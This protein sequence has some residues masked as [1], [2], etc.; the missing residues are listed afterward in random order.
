MKTPLR[1]PKPQKLITLETQ[2]QT[3]QETLL[4][5]RQ[6]SGHRSPQETDQEI[7]Q[8]IRHKIYKEFQKESGDANLLQISHNS[9]EKSAIR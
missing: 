7:S 8:Q 3:R 2:T 4:A 9:A 5:A 1:T 6:E